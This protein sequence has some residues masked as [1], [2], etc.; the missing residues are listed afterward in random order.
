MRP[1][2]DFVVEIK[3]TRRQPKLQRTSIWGDTDLKAI[4]QEVENLAPHIFVEDAPSGSDPIQL[5]PSSS[6]SPQVDGMPTSA[7]G[8]ETITLPIFETSDNRL[9]SF[10]EIVEVKLEDEVKEPV[11]IRPTVPTRGPSRKKPRVATKSAIGSVSRE[12]LAYLESENRRLKSI[13]RS[14]LDVENRTLNSMLSRVTRF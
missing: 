5:P 8:E 2:R 1:R 9:N 4:K 11:T 13:W 12:E 3:S 14:R 6:H 7:A 10:P